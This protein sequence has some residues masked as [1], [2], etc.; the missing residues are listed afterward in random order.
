M[1]RRADR[2][3]AAPTSR[4][5]G[6]LCASHFE[7]LQTGNDRNPQPPRR[8]GHGHSSR[9]IAPMRS[10]Q[11]FGSLWHLAGRFVGS[12]LP[13]GPTK[14]AQGWAAN[15]L[16]PTEIDLFAA[17]SGPDRRHAIGVAQRAIRLLDDSDEIAAPPPTREFVA[18][19]LLHDVGKTE[20]R[21]GT[22]GRVAATVA[23]LG[24]GR[25]RVVAWASDRPSSASA[26]FGHG[27]D[28]DEVSTDGGRSPTTPAWSMRAWR[29]RMGRYLMHD[30]IGARLLEEAGSDV[31]TVRWAREHHLPEGRWSV[32]RHLGHA[33]KEADGD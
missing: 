4:R 24:L 30:S 5:A 27:D 10:S 33:L 26:P 28:H 3:R 1:V 22:F 29:A 11:G 12:L 20:A 13:V 17:M 16:L 15:Y 32:E 21:L 8:Q 7:Q 31:L 14:S 25:S 6:R 23:A 2:V 18:A 19:A 9:S